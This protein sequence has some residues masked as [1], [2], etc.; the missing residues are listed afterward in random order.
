MAAR[1]RKFPIP[2]TSTPQAQLEDSSL[3]RMPRQEMPI[4][5]ASAAEGPKPMAVTGNVGAARPSL[6]QEARLD[7]EAQAEGINSTTA[8]TLGKGAPPANRLP[9]TRWPAIGTAIPTDGMAA[10]VLLSDGGFQQTAGEADQCQSQPKS[11]QVPMPGTVK[12][13][14]KSRQAWL[15]ARLEMVSPRDEAGDTFALLNESQSK[16]FDGLYEF[17]T[18]SGFDGQNVPCNRTRASFQ[19]KV[20][21]DGALGNAL[22]SEKEMADVR[23]FKSWTDHWRMQPNTQVFNSEWSQNDDESCGAQSG[24]AT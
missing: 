1:P 16:L 2:E 3:S 12:P 5:L 22:L 9:P 21:S 24:S 14:N 23:A 15:G 11:T 4:L 17:Y 18:R 6:F 10:F 8:H 19:V 7:S 13:H 20:R